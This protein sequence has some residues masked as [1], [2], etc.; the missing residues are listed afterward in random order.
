M[1]T[2]R[3]HGHRH[4][5]QERRFPFFGQLA[6]QPARVGQDAGAGGCGRVLLHE[7]R[8]AEHDVRPP[9]VQTLP[10]VLQKPLHGRVVQLLVPVPQSLHEAAHVR[11]L[12]CGG[13]VHAD[14]H[15]RDRVLAPLRAIP[16]QQRQ[17][18][19]F[20]PD[21]V[22]GQGHR[23]RTVLYVFHAVPLSS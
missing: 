16:H 7:I 1:D 11:A 13:Q 12:E 22:D 19:S 6:G 3:H 8:K 20:D 17:L 10:H 9:G 15:V 4:F 23:S 18:Q 5:K 21:P 2:H 14:V